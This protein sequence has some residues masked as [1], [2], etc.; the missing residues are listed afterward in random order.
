VLSRQRQRL[1]EAMRQSVAKSG[2]NATSVSDVASLAHVAR[3]VFY[4]AFPGGKD[5]CF[6]VLYDGI[7]DEILA[8]G[9][10][11]YSPSGGL[12]GVEAALRATAMHLARDPAAAKICLI[13]I[14]A[15]GTAGLKHRD[16]VLT[17]LGD[18]L[19]TVLGADQPNGSISS[20]KLRALIGGCYQ[21]LYLTVAEERAAELPA[22]VPDML[23]M[24]LAYG[25]TPSPP[26]SPKG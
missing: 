4:K 12:P 24:M 3:P 8:V 21:L 25:L 7:I 26:T 14:T 20:T 23:Y 17:R 18:L 13:E 9:A 22:L 1:I 11:A 6:L 15:L 5:E 2:Y 19:H 16:A 10:K